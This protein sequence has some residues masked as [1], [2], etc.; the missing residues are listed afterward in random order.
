MKARRICLYGGAGVGKSKL[1]DR[2]S[3]EL[4]SQQYDIELVKEWIKQWA[5]EGRTPKGNNQ[6]FIFSNQQ[7]LEESALGHV[8]TIV[9][10][11][12]LLLNAAYSARCQYEGTAEIIKFAQRFDRDYPSLNLFIKR[13]VP[14]KQKGRYGDEADS[15]DFDGFLMQFLEQHLDQEVH[16]ITVD[17][18]QDTIE[19]IKANIDGQTQ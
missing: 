10:D 1:A 18:F 8:Q 5:Y 6:L 3:G 4:G 7:Y 17:N 13:T 16:P 11:S 9:T 19:F 2:I 14:F 12:P 15:R